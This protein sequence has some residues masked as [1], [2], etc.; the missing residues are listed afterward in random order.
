MG[1][2][3][4]DN[5]NNINERN[6][7]NVALSISVRGTQREEHPLA[8]ARIDMELTVT[9]SDATEDDVKLAIAKSEEKFCPVWA[10]IKGNVEVVAAVVMKRA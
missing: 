2:N 7:A 3:G 6:N 10:M 5:L 9:S 8:F 1:L 4:N